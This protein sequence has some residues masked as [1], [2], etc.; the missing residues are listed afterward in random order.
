M[1]TRHIRDKMRDEMRNK[2]KPRGRHPYQ[3][4]SAISLRRYRQPGRYA[5]GNGLYLVVD[6]S[7]AQR[8][9]WRGVV[10]G[11]RCDLG[12]GSVDVVPLADAR[13]QA[14]LCR[15]QARQGENPKAAR[16]RT[17][18]VVPTFA[19][20]ARQVH[21]EQRETFRNPK[22]AAQWLASLELDVLPTIGAQRVDVITSGDV[23]RVLTAV[24]TTKPE[25]ARRLK[26]RMKLVFDW[27][28]ASGFRSG[29]NPTEGMTKV[30]PK[31]RG[32]KQ[33][34]AALPYRDVPAFVTR[35]S[36]LSDMQPA[37]R[38]GLEFLILTATRT[39]E[40]QRATWAEVDWMQ[41]SG[42]SPVRA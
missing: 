23:L 25:T 20:A 3:R 24:W 40:V 17:R 31:H 42:R 21:T 26:Q 2:G 19:D 28:K 6:P 30:L 12:L 35:L 5:D 11:K 29:D 10:Q 22:H 37:V 41:P 39:N 16:T 4:L 8:W 32:D 1:N 34:H 9:I 33:H 14:R 13:E 15:Y 36:A 38:L 7:G 27:A 18:R